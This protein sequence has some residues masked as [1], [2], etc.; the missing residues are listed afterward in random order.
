MSTNDFDVAEIREV[1]TLLAA[2][3]CSTKR[4]DAAETVD[5]VHTG[6]TVGTGRRLALV[7]VCEGKRSSTFKLVTGVF[8]WSPF[9]SH[10]CSISL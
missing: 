2:S 6:G 9:D 5:L 3:S 7:Y 4:T 8:S 10:I 1:F